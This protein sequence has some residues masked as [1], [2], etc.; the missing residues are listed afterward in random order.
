MKS[1]VEKLAKAKSDAETYKNACKQLEFE[2]DQLKFEKDDTK[3]AYIKLRASYDSLKLKYEAIPQ[4]ERKRNP[5]VSAIPDRTKRPPTASSSSSNSNGG[6]SMS[7]W[8]RQQEAER[9]ERARREAEDARLNA[10]FERSDRSGLSRTNSTTRRPTTN[11]H[12]RR[13][14]FIEGF[15]PRKPSGSAA[16]VAFDDVAHTSR[17]D[18][19]VLTPRESHVV[20]SQMPRTVPSSVGHHSGG[21][22]AIIDDDFEDGDY[23]ARPVR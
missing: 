5:M 16:R 8:A 3:N 10:R 17:Y 21:S 2:K 4:E 12:H 14:S 19:P 20:Y 13:D 6:G 15:G 22:S 11:G 9:L 18:E 7:S 23:H 1:L